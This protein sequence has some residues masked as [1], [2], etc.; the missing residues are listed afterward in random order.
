MVPD[1]NPGGGGAALAECGAA[2]VIV[3]A[4]GAISTRLGVAVVTPEA[5]GALA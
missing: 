3:R 2:R 4:V 1:A 5:H